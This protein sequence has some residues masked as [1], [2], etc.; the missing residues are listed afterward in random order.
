MKVFIILQTIFNSFEFTGVPPPA[1]TAD[2]FTQ[3]VRFNKKMAVKL[4]NLLQRQWFSLTDA[5][6]QFFNVD[7]EVIK[8]LFLAAD[9]LNISSLY[10][11]CLFIFL[12]G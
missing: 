2:T 11:Y 1:V 7:I 12:F 3:E 4:D 6:R 10:L 9:F 8:E 5:E